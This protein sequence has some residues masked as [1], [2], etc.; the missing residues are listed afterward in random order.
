MPAYPTLFVT[1][2]VLVGSVCVLYIAFGKNRR[3]GGE[4]ALDPAS[5][6]A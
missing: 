2:A 3:P 4:V 1:M 6:V 5:E